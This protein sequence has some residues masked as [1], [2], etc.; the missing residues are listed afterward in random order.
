MEI[1]G[2]ER[3]SGAAG[4]GKARGANARQ[5]ALL[6]FGCAALALQALAPGVGRAFADEGAGNGSGAVDA[7]FAEVLRRF[8]DS[9]RFGCGYVKTHMSSHTWPGE[10]RV[11]KYSARSGWTLL[12]VDGETPTEE[13]AEEYRKHPFTRSNRLLRGIDLAKLLSPQQARLVEET[14]ETLTYESRPGPGQGW[15]FQY[16]DDMVSRIVIDKRALRPLHLTTTNEES[17]SYMTGVRIHDYRYD[18]AFEVDEARG[19]V[20]PLREKREAGG[21]A[22]L[23]KRIEFGN[24]ASYADFDCSEAD[25]GASAE[26]G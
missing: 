9:P 22:F 14:R 13:Q 21:R 24:S 10:E 3:G 19:I 8:A 12:S 7:G 26:T 2:K 6:L 17:L 5:R 20:L 18:L 1:H 25:R 11:G 23:V 15:E 16:A 4:R